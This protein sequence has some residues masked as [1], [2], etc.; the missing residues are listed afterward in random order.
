M[1]TTPDRMVEVGASDTEA[2]P[3]RT[4][5]AVMQN[6]WVRDPDQLRRILARHDEAFRRRMIAR[7]L[8]AG[9]VSGR[10]IKVAFGDLCNQI[11]WEEA[12]R[13]I[14]GR[15]NECP[16]ADLA[17]LRDCLTTLRPEIVLAFGAHAQLA[18]SRVYGSPHAY[19]LIPAPHPAARHPRV[20]ELLADAAA[21]LRAALASSPVKA[22][23]NE[24]AK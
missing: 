5:L 16:P 8:F 21:Q 6:Q 7:L 23:E 10:R 12:S 20:T 24:K 18:L 22:P 2:T 4:I 11:V 17:H 15:S 13:V 19:R 1:T 9:C 3:V 14:T